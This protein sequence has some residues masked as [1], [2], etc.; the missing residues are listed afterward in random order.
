MKVKYGKTLKIGEVQ[1]TNLGKEGVLLDSRLDESFAAIHKTVAD[2]VTN[3]GA[4]N[5]QL[6]SSGISTYL[7]GLT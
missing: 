5:Y 4:W 6:T 3:F 7:T 1:Q 2:T